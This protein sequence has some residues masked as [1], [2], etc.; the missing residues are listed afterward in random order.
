MGS[1]VGSPDGA[2]PTRQDKLRGLGYILVCLGLPMAIAFGMVLRM[3]LLPGRDGSLPLPHGRSLVPAFVLAAIGAGM[4]LAGV[5]LL[6]RLAEGRR[7]EAFRKRYLA[8]QPEATEG[9]YAAA[10]LQTAAAPEPASPLPQAS[11]SQPI[12]VPIVQADRQATRPATAQPNGIDGLIM[13][14]NVIREAPKALNATFIVIYACLSAT[15]FHE[16]QKER[17]YHKN[18]R[19][20]GV[21]AYARVVDHGYE[22]DRHGTTYSVRYAY[23]TKTPYHYADMKW[24]EVTQFT[25]EH[26]NVG[27]SIPILIDPNDP[28]AT[29]TH[30]HQSLTDREL[31]QNQIAEFV[32]FNLMIGTFLLLPWS[33]SAFIAKQIRKSRQIAN[34]DAV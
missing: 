26:Y 28:K 14:V 16:T 5:T 24:Q 1:Q 21:I 17:Y 10:A 27:S 33:F 7:R 2:Q 4:A 15:V 19:D 8:P 9:V 11:P 32:L 34:P 31:M 6:N 25:F 18:L 30:V 23:S 20:H 22:H 29:W 13:M 12:F 3:M